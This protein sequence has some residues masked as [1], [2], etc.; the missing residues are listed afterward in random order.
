MLSSAPRDLQG[1]LPI[2]LDHCSTTRCWRNNFTTTMIVKTVTTG[3][4]LSQLLPGRHGPEVILLEKTADLSFALLFHTRRLD[5][6]P[7]RNQVAYRKLLVI[8]EGAL[9]FPLLLERAKRQRLR[10]RSNGPT[11]TRSLSYMISSTLA[12]THLAVRRTL[13]EPQYHPLLVVHAAY[14]SLLR[15]S[16]RDVMALALC[17]PTNL[18]S[19]LVQRLDLCGR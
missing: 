12:N 6:F 13:E 14:A 2:I 15:T 5:P 8:G 11:S 7:C 16:S 3:L 10:C 17:T 18:R 19:F 1:Q 9:P 4:V